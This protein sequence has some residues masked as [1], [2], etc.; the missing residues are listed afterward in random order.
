[1]KDD[2]LF[3]SSGSKKRAQTVV[4]S[5]HAVICKKDDALTFSFRVADV[6]KVRLELKH[7]V[8]NAIIGQL[9]V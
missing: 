6:G 8:Q 1:M 5:K 7:L 3:A 4:F 2:S 9:P